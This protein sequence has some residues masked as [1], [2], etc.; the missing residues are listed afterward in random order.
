[1]SWRSSFTTVREGVFVYRVANGTGLLAPQMPPFW[2]SNSPPLLWFLGIDS[3][4]RSQEVAPF[5]LVWLLAFGKSELSL[6]FGGTT[7]FLMHRDADA[8]IFLNA[9]DPTRPRGDGH[10]ALSLLLFF[11]VRWHGVCFQFFPV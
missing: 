10:D 8:V 7:G 4:T 1:M 11:F 5:F 2:V 9:P 3:E 6:L